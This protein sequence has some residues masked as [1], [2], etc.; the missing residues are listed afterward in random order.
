MVGGSIMKNV[1][2]QRI[3]KRIKSQGSVKR[4]S[5]ATTKGMIHHGK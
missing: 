2:A 4:I 3:N 1:E 5:G